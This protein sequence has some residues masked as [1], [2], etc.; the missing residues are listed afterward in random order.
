MAAAASSEGPEALVRRFWRRVFDERDLTAAWEML[1]ADFRCR[2]FPRRSLRQGHVAGEVALQ[3]R[4]QR[5][6]E[7]VGARG[8]QRLQLQ[9]VAV[10]SRLTSREATSAPRAS[11]SPAGRRHRS[12]A[13]RRPRGRR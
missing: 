8:G 2:K 6:D 7:V 13:P 9:H 1:T 10:I 5:L 11:R 3:G 4:R 12:R